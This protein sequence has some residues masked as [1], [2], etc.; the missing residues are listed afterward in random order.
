MARGVGTGPFGKH[1]LLALDTCLVCVLYRFVSGC[2]FVE[3]AAEDSPTRG[4]QL[5]M[6]GQHRSHQALCPGGRGPHLHLEGPG[7]GV[8]EFPVL[9]APSAWQGRPF[10]HSWFC[11]LLL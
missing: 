5:G 4:W 11:I 7:L 8:P 2:V 9:R 10:G 6:W 3:Q 1:R